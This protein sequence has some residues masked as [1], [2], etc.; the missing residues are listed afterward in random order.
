MTFRSVVARFV[1][2]TR[3]KLDLTQIQMRKKTGISQS[4]WSEMES[5]VSGFSDDMIDRLAKGLGMTLQHLFDSFAATAARMNSKP[6]ESDAAIVSPPEPGETVQH[7]RKSTLRNG[8][9]QSGK[10]KR[11]SDQAL[12]SKGT[13]RP[14][15]HRPP[16]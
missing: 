4:S 15:R 8:P 2:E 10:G 14:Q 9:V 7:G 1:R 11:Q 12:P 5:G 3:E 6:E 16:R 13:R